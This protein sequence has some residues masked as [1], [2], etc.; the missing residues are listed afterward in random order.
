MLKNLEK[1]RPI[2][3]IKQRIKMEE[4]EQDNDKFK[5]AM[6]FRLE[7]KFSKDITELL[8]YDGR[9]HEQ[10]AKYLHISPDTVYAW[11]VRFGIE[12]REIKNI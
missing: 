4:Q 7:R 2:S 1:R 9:T 8:A 3:K 5:T 6:M 12:S 11:R 10:M